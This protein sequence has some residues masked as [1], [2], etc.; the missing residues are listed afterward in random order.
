MASYSDSYG[1]RCFS[2]LVDKNAIDLWDIY[3]K[4]P[5]DIMKNRIIRY[6][7]PLV[8]IQSFNFVEKYIASYGYDD[9]IRKV[10]DELYRDYSSTPMYF[11][12]AFLNTEKHR[13]VLDWI[14][15]Y[16]FTNDVNRYRK[17]IVAILRDKFSS[18]LLTPDEL[19]TLLTFFR[20][21]LDEQTRS[22]YLTQEERRRITAS[23]ELVNQIKDTKEIATLVDLESILRY[24]SST[25]WNRNGRSFRH[26]LLKFRVQE[27]LSPPLSSEEYTALVG[28]CYKFAYAGTATSTSIKTLL[29]GVTVA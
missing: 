24:M 1:H 4:Y 22:M 12:R 5:T 29:C 14:E 13:T 2:L 25:D 15:G 17:L 6:V 18:S 9:N 27:L 7:S 3:N 16:Y 20:D 23:R 10:I 11:K 21:D 26:E 19:D 8:N 28:I